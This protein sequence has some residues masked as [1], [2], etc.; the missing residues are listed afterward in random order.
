MAFP[1]FEDGFNAPTQ[2]V[3]IGDVLDG[4][5]ALRDIGDEDRP[6]TKGYLLLAGI[7]PAISFF[8]LMQFSSTFIGHLLWDRNTDKTHRNFGL[9]AEEYP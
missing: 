7:K 3:D 1:G 2:S 9:F 4:P 8:V 5:N 6:P